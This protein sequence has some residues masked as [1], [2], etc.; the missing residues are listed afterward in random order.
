MNHTRYAQINATRDAIRKSNEIIFQAIW[1]N[2]DK[3]QHDS[4]IIN[5]ARIDRTQDVL[6]NLHLQ[7]LEAIRED[8]DSINYD[9][10]IAPEL[11]LMLND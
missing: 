5:S 9:T 10:Y 11:E 3:V 8:E 1:R 7:A 4:T 6:S 2:I